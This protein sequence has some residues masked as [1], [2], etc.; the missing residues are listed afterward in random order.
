MTA[1][2]AVVN[3]KAVVLAADSAATI[4]TT[5]KIYRA[6]KLFPL[7]A[8]EPIGMMVYNDLDFMDIPWETFIKTYAK[9]ASRQMQP[10]VAVYMSDFLSYASKLVCSGD[11]QRVDKV[12]GDD[13][14]GI[15]IAGFG[16]DELRPTLMAVRVQNAN[17][18]LI[19][20]LEDSSDFELED[21]QSIVRPF[22]QSEMV[23]RFFDGIDG[24]L[25]E[26]VKSLSERRLARFAK[27][28]SKFLP[29]DKHQVE[30]AVLV[31]KHAKAYE[32]GLRNHIEKHYSA[33]IVQMVQSLPKEELAYLAESLVS[34]MSLKLRVSPAQETVGGPIDVAVISKGDG[35]VWHKRDA[36]HRRHQPGDLGKV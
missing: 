33:P 8:N 29:E 13:Y 24:D 18:D 31:K 14:S 35:F 26:R 7:R 3:N 27:D 25:L 2:I 17:G 23:P 10:T 22:A 30:L 19:H 12:E 15:I 5:G 1:E 21:L 4:G 28:V 34:L 9:M 32:R 20:D 6:D 36:A 11:T 16:E